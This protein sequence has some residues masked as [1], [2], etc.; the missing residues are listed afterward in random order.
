M[1][2]LE[3]CICE[4]SKEPCASMVEV[5]STKLER[6]LRLSNSQGLHARPATF[7][8]KLLRSTRSSVTFSYKQQTVD[9]HSVLHLLMLGAPK[10][11]YITVSAIGS[12]ALET[13]E[14][15]EKAFEQK[16]GDA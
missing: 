7:I 8:V 4:A 3:D 14:K 11:A 1:S 13:I 10:N 16:F 9:A 2:A 12:D 6:K 15:L 5:T